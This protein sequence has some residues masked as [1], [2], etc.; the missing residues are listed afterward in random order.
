MSVKSFLFFKYAQWKVRKELKT[1]ARAGFYQNKF[2]IPWLRENKNTAFGIE[3]NF[4]NIKDISTYWS[5]I[6]IRNYEDFLPYIEKIKQGNSQVLTKKDPQ[7]FSLTSGTI[8]GSKYIPISKAGIQHQIEAAVKVL[9]FYSVNSGHADFMNY[10]MIFLQGSPALDYSFKIPSGRL[11]GIVYHHIPKFF[12]RNKL[13]SYE[14]NIIEDWQT[15]LTKIVEET[16]REDISILGGIPPWCLQ[17]FE[18]LLDI[19]KTKNLKQLYP[20]LTMYMHGGLDFSNYKASMMRV[21]GADIP[22]MQIFPASEGFFALQDRMA[23]EDM[24]L[25]LNQ[26]VYYEFR[27]YPNEGNTTIT[28]EDVIVNTH[29]EL[30]ITNNSGLY[31][32][33]IG[34]LIEFTSIRPYRIKVVGRTRQFISAFGEHVIAYEIESAMA[35]ASKS[36]NIEVNDYYVYPDVNRK[37]Y[38]WLVEFHSELSKAILAALTHQL[39]KNLA[40]LNKYY[41]H[42]LYGK[43]ISSCRIISVC[44]GFFNLE[45]EK[46]GKLGGQNKVVHLGMKKIYAHN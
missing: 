26:G 19:S 36:L 24:L 38:V 6:P 23:A 32:Y 7:Y 18:K 11:S 46:A 15:K 8:A 43:I 39:D 29:Y 33:A 4:E 9:C 21:L 25:L 31:R 10:K 40:S 5:R 44:R 35:A 27:L 22:C 3:H 20:H 12:Q 37:Q 28:L 1:H 16:Y 45:R 17:Y 13:P 34:D 30:I 41:A 14:V 42:L 2:L